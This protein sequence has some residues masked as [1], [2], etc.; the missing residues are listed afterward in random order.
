M[1]E[2]KYICKVKK[3]FK[4]TDGRIYDPN[5]KYESTDEERVEALSTEN[6]KYKEPFIEII[7]EVEQKEDGLEG[8]EGAEYPKHTGGGYYE[9]SNGEKVQGKDAAIE[10]EKELNEVK[11]GDQ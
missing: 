4:D 3:M 8:G 11:E 6:N 2:I 1:S 9:L 10:A 5:H 7:E